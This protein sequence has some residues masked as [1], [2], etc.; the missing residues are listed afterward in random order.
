MQS[1]AMSTEGTHPC[2]NRLQASLGGAKRSSAGTAETAASWR[3]KFLKHSAHDRLVLSYLTLSYIDININTMI[4][5]YIIFYDVILYYVR[6][7]YIIC[8]LLY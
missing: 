4:L 8:I 6:S 5:S 3:L 2:F 7:Y 1:P